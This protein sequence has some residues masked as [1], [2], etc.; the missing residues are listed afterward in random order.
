MTL[1]KNDNKTIG[2]AIA[3][4]LVA[5][6]RLVPYHSSLGIDDSFHSVAGVHVSTFQPTTG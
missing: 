4:T 5:R 3:M 1:I 2:S 6:R